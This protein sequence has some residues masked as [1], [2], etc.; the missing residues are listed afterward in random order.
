VKQKLARIGLEVNVEGLPPGPGY[1]ERLA[2]PDEPWDIAFAPYQADYVDPYSFLNLQFDGRFIG[3]NNLSRLDSPRY[4]RLLRQAASLRG[5]ARDRAY[6]RLDVQLAR[7]AAPMIAFQ[8]PNE[9]TLV[10]RRVDPRCIILR[11]ALDLTAVCL[12]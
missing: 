1:F 5:R 8:N 9:P 3:A 7:D 4:N 11:P 10:S 6:G 12:K 2:S